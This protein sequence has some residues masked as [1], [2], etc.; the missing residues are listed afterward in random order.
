MADTDTTD[1]PQIEVPTVTFSEDE[2]GNITASFPS[3][4]GAKPFVVKLQNMNWGLIE[5]LDRFGEEEAEN[6]QLLEFF[7]EYVVGGPRAIP[8]KHTMTVFNAIRAYI[9]Q[10][11]LDAKNE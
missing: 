4:N 6:R 9:E 2:A 7:N 3:M 5:D 11:S 1:A 10:V 8:I